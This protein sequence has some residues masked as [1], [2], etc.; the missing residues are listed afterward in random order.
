M[1]KRKSRGAVAVQKTQP[2]SGANVLTVQA[3]Y[4]AASNGRRMA[5]WNAPGT[6]PQKAI[7]GLA[8]IRD[9]SRDAGRNEWAAAS[10]VRVMTTN[11]IG[12]GIV[13]RPKTK[14]KTLKAKLAD[15]WGDWTETADADGVLDFYGLQTLAAHTWFV[16]GECF[17][18]LRYR[19]LNDGLPVPLQVQLLE[20]DM[21]PLFDYDSWPGMATGSKI[22]QGVEFNAFGQRVAYWMHKEH[23]GDGTSVSVGISDLTRVPA[24]QVLHVFRPL[25]PGQIR[26]VP[27]TAP[28]LAKRRGVM[29][30]DDA[31][32]TRQHIANLFT[33][34]IKRPMPTDAEADINPMTGK[35]FD[36]APNGAPMAALEPG[37]SQELLPGED[38]LF[39]SPPDSG[40]NYSEFMRHQ[41]LGLFAGEGVPYELGSGDIK[42]VSDRTLRV[43]INEFRRYCEQI[44]WNIL[45]PQF[46]RPIRNAWAQAGLLAGA[47]AEAES[48]EA[49]RVVWSPQGWAYVHP[50]QDVQAKQLE[51][52]AGFR[53]RSSV[54]TER[55]DDP[56]QVDDERAEDDL[57]EQELG[58]ADDPA[59]DP[60]TEA[61]AEAAR[62]NAERIRAET[63]AIE[64]RDKREALAATEA[65]KL[66]SAEIEKARA[67][68]RLTLA[69][70]DREDAEKA[71]AA[72]RAAADQAEIEAAAKRTELDAALKANESAER[73]NA[74]REQM[75][76]A[77]AES[78]ARLSAHESAEAHAKEMRA[79]EAEAE[80]NRVAVS[81]LELEA[82]QAGLEEL[83]GG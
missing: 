40:A 36:Y 23:P 55:G 76:Q 44:Q 49:R 30:F 68:A 73:I 72:A 9:R 61:E 34:F 41:H 7:T 64:N 46:C 60:V 67:E 26:G 42:D 17:A 27:E 33:L 58:I 25:R 78:A 56:E 47:L 4:D 35:V 81:R 77:R 57:R 13:A 8:K 53:S 28:T 83:R 11:L 22:R 2:V 39:S 1:A 71:A 21:V 69:K 51:V 43:R 48:A 74:I 38:V 52:E 20:P 62:A 15:L 18:R 24:E 5:G 54:I 59:A 3:R 32:L 65:S 31:V 75:E 66:R 63:R 82:A 80:R 14:D 37:I 10:S 6:G 12:T 70:A 19:R 79:A 50:T 16:S 45:I 29:D